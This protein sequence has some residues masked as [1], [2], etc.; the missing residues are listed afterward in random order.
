MEFT[1]QYKSWLK[2]LKDKIRTAQLKAALSV[3]SQL[4]HLYWELGEMIYEKQEKEKWGSKIIDKI[5][6]DLKRELPDSSGFS[7]SN[8]YNIRKFFLFYKKS[9]FVHQVGGQNTRN[10]I[11]HQ[12]GGQLKLPDIL[13]RVPWRHQV[14]IISKAR[15]ANEALFYL[16]KT[17]ENNWSRNILDLQIASKLFDRQGRALT[18]FE[19]T[20]PAPQKDLA[21]ET[22]K[23]PY[24]FDFLG[25][26]EDM[27]ERELEN[28][29]IENITW[30]LLEL[31]KGFA[32]MGRQYPLL[33]GDKERKLDLLFYHTRLHSYVVFDIKTGEFEPEYAGKMN[34]YLS[35]VD[36]QL[37]SPEDEPS[38]GVILCKSKTAIDVEYALRDMG[39]P[40]G[41]SEFSFSELP[42]KIKKNLPSKNELENEFKRI[43]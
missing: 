12:A 10:E 22:L 2:Q 26:Q 32:Y 19:N 20:L 35:A 42:D 17:I 31:G 16:N 38:I 28:R 15:N 9:G 1:E 30:F 8:L 29:L 4:I 7:R 6:S 23:D 34:Y 5:A 33:I 40:M 39:K 25:L 13:L 14:L 41:I 37:K 3:N 43:M 36:E 11:V 24:V 21:I 27:Q 18:N